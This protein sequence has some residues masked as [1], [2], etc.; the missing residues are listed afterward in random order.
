M[1]MK[2]NDNSNNANNKND[3]D[4]CI[5]RLKISFSGFY[6]PPVFPYNLG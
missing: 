3:D 1:E 2:D 6:L 5:M 4:Y